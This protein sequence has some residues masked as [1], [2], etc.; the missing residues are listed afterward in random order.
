MNVTVRIDDL[1]D[2][3]QRVSQRYQASVSVTRDGQFLSIC[4]IPSEPI[5]SFINPSLSREFR[6]ECLSV[7]EDTFTTTLHRLNAILRDIREHL[8]K[9]D[10]VT[11]KLRL[12]LRGLVEKEDESE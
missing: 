6:L 12:K 9:I 5:V 10:E 11:R 3:L 1:I 4:L 8:E 2:E 7:D